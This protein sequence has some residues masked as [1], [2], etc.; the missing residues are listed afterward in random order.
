MPLPPL[1]WRT[2]LRLWKG[3]RHDLCRPTT[4]LE[5]VNPRRCLEL[6]DPRRHELASHTL[7]RSVPTRA[8]W[9]RPTLI[10]DASS[11]AGLAH[12]DPC[13]DGKGEAIGGGGRRGK[14]ETG[15]W[16]WWR[17]GS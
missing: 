5:L 7:P 4:T 1:P 6:A 9:P 11:F 2:P 15:G 13:M 17:K 16:R 3:R 8:P 10:S 12:L 14:G